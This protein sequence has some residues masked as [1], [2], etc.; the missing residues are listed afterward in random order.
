[1]VKVLAVLAEGK[2][3]YKVQVM[4]AVGRD[5]LQEVLQVQAVLGLVKEAV[6]VLLMGLSQHSTFCGHA[7][8][9]HGSARFWKSMHRTRKILVLPDLR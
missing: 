6:L 3:E 2:V 7:N 8:S 4:M 5:L 1:M 9:H